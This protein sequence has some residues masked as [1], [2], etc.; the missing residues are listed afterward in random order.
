M[1]P[2]AYADPNSDGRRDGS[3]AARAPQGPS[4]GSGQYVSYCVRLCDG[5]YFPIQRHANT[6]PAQLCSAMCPAARTKIFAG[7]EIGRAVAPDGSRYGDIDE[8]FTYRERVVDNCTCNGKDAFGLAPLN[9]D[10][11]PTLRT[12][13][14][15]ATGSGLMAYTA[16]P[17]SRRGGEAAAN[18]TPIDNSR[19]SGDLRDKLAKVP[20]ATAN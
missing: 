3:R 11:D 15:V 19:A 18:F 14:I 9:V 13:D 8:A 7:G 10:S 6:T 16:A 17:R 5:R 1:A 20:V 12:G 4:G 2:H